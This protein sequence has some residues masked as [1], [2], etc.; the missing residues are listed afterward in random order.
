M[1]EFFWLQILKCDDLKL[2]CV[3]NDSKP[4]FFRFWTVD[5]TKQDI[6]IGSKKLKQ[7]FFVIFRQFID[8]M[9]IQFIEKII[10]RLIDNENNS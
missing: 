10:S 7:A 8:K 1:Q 3:I 5:L 2:V 9:I 4:T 6:S